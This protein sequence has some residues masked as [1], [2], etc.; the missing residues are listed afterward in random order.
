MSFSR[1]T[2]GRCERS[3]ESHALKFLVLFV[4]PAPLYSAGFVVNS[5][6]NE[7]IN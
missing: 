5:Y 2:P 3:E 1:R 4:P 6:S 7:I